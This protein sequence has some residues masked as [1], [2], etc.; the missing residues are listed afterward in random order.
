MS[1]NCSGGFQRNTVLTAFLVTLLFK[2][3]IVLPLRQT[4]ERV[5][6]RLKAFE[7]ARDNRVG[8]CGLDANDGLAL[9]VELEN[10]AIGVIQSSR[11]AS[12]YT[13][14]LKLRLFWGQ[15]WRWRC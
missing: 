3:W 10:G 13:D 5:F 1:Q 14:E 4:I 12:G 2:D 11:W 7:K 8:E 6:V 15:R 9:T